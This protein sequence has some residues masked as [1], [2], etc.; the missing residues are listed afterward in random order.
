VVRGAVARRRFE[1]LRERHL[2]AIL[3]QKY[4]R[5]QAACQNFQ[6]TKERIVN[7]QAGTGPF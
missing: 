7:C 3:I 2:A 4:A 5:R 6:L 1:D